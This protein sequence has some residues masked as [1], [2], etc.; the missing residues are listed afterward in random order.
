[1]Q[2]IDRA[3]KAHNRRLD[4]AKLSEALK[5]IVE[6]TMIKSFLDEKY[7]VGFAEG[8]TKGKAEGKAEAVLTFLRAKFHRVPRSIEKAICQKTDPRA[9]DSLAAHIVKCDSLKGF[10][11]ILR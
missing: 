1:M 10:E 3:F 8:E 11:K 7:D 6:E 5:P 2:F 9:L 4:E